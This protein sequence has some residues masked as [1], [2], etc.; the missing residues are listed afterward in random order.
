M[1]STPSPLIEADELPDESLAGDPESSEPTVTPTAAEG[2]RA[3]LYRV[4]WRWHFY[5]GLITAPI[6]LIASATGAI[7][8]FHNEISDWAN[9]DTTFVEP[10]GERLSYDEQQAKLMEQAPDVTEIDA[11]SVQNDPRRA[12]KFYVHI[13][14]EGADEQDPG[15]ERH[16]IYSVNPYTGALLGTSILEENFFSVVLDLHRS[17][18]AGSTG[19]LLVELA[20]SWGLVLLLTGLYLW[21]PRGKQRVLGV[22]IPRLKAK[23]Y[24]ILRDL[25]AVVGF[26]TAIFA[27]IILFTG[28]FISLVWGGA[29]NAVSMKMNQSLMGFLMPAAVESAE[30]APGGKPTLESLVT[31]SMEFSQPGDNMYLQFA[32]MPKTAHK[33]YLMKDGDTNTVRGLDLDPQSGKLIQATL[34]KDLTPMVSLLAVAV[35]LHQGKTFGMPSKI[36]AFITCLALVGMVI[37]GIWM[38]WDRRPRGTTGFPRRVTG[39]K[40]P[41]WVVAATIAVC[42]L[43]PTVG[44][45]LIV[46]LAGDWLFRRLTPG[47]A[48]A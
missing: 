43:L 46:I 32:E 12:T 1:S 26:Y 4:I 24:I 27:A 15:T 33:V 8:T 23:P 2:P 6:M 13:H 25:H 36:I 44:A 48:N 19:R 5:A 38:W 11:I 41:T 34:T 31:T 39:G 47:T 18:F 7:Y 3:N 22:F 45:S 20:T 40:L 10:Q 37:T 14:P 35:S 16:R 30:P 29:F 21:W 42:I 28:L 17:L 9:R